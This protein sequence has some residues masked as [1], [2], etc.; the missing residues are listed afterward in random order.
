M[1]LFESAFLA[2]KEAIIIQDGRRIYWC[3]DEAARLCGYE[4]S[5]EMIGIEVLD[6]ISSEYRYKAVQTFE[7]IN[8][9]GESKASFKLVTKQG[10]YKSIKTTNS[11]FRHKDQVFYLGLISELDEADVEERAW[12]ILSTMRHEAMTPISNSLGNVELIFDS[13]G[14]G[15]TE[16]VR[17]SLDVIQRNLVRLK[18]SYDRIITLENVKHK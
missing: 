13:Y 7:E 16:N 1:S 11:L 2:L 6:F 5:S 3:N 12:H 18:D 9:E 14:D 17:R 10:S 15:L 8:S 4:S